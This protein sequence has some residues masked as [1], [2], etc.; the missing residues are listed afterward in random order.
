MT[1]TWIIETQDLTKIY[2]NGAQVRAL[3]GVNI[4]IASGEF[5]AVMGPSGS[6]KST[7]LNMLGALDRP[8]TGR[9]LVGGQD[10]ATVKDLDGFRAHTV[11]F[12]FQL[13]N[14]IP[15]LNALENIEVPM[16]GQPLSPAARRSRAE[17]LL[18]L[19]GLSERMHH[20]PNQLS[21]GQRQRIAI[22]RSLA[23]KPA[24]V[25][26]DE[27]TGNLDSQSGAEVIA[28]MRRLNQE[29]GT[30]FV[31]VTHDLAVARQTNRVLVMH[32]GKIVDDHHIGSPIEEDLKAFR[33]SGLGRAIVSGND[34]AVEPLG[35]TPGEWDV[36]QRLLAR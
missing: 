16:I 10:I 23:N 30:T 31:V 18:A 13:H 34:V 6:G 36:L 12:V 8:S 20:L 17:E 35:I 3:N 22:A 24:L 14:L 21:G 25:L 33:D 27:P 28:L 2:G 11:G 32:D 7:L 15:T 4:Q 9:V 26:A 5:V 19:V 1:S 29:L